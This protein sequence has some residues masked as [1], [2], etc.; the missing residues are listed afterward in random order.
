MVSGEIGIELPGATLA[1]RMVRTALATARSPC[2]VA[3]SPYMRRWRKTRIFEVRMDQ[4]S[5]GRIAV[6]NLG[7]LTFHG[8]KA[9]PRSAGVWA[10]KNSRIPFQSVNNHSRIRPMGVA[11][12]AISWG[13]GGFVNM[14]CMEC[15][16]VIWVFHGLPFCFEVSRE[17]HMRT[18][19]KSREPGQ[20]GA[21]ASGQTTN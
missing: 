1:D 4:C 10:L 7:A 21:C 15:L 20:R 14:P 12:V 17:S 9:S 6:A 16:G 2:V 19:M 11:P 8:T 13:R 5:F 3:S 18:N